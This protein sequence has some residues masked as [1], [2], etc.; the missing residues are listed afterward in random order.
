MGGHRFV[1]RIWRTPARQKPE[2]R[3]VVMLDPR[4]EHLV[5]AL[6]DELPSYRFNTGAAVHDAGVFVTTQ[7]ESAAIRALSQRYPNLVI[8]VVSSSGVSNA[9]DHGTF[10]AAVNAG[11]SA[12]LVDASVSLLAA[13]VANVGRGPGRRAAHPHRWAPQ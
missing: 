7:I 3:R 9:L 13:H 12:Y 5:G 2:S 4:L 10:V 8:V 6:Q 11:A 1:S